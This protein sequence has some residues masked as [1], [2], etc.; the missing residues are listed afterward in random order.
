MKK[1]MK[2]HAI[3]IAIISV[4]IVALYSFIGPKPV[5]KGPPKPTDRYVRITNA[6]WGL[7]CNSVIDE[8]SR[9]RS[10]IP[11]AKDAAGKVIPAE[12]LKR[13]SV[14]NV[15]PVV[16]QAC[17]GQLACEV[18]AND[19]VF[20]ITLPPGCY[21][22]LNVNYRCSDVDRLAML[23]IDQGQYLKIDCSAQNASAPAPQHP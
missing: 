5:E 16:K 9:A 12:P 14:D 3:A 23:S 1:N 19:D 13:V 17:E 10:A 20:N 21:K 4:V 18:P 22:K 8:V 11:L 6:T 7:E 2:F 15:L